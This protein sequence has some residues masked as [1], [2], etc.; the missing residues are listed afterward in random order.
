MSYLILAFAAVAGVIPIVVG[1]ILVGIAPSRTD[2]VV[3]VLRAGRP[4]AREIVSLLAA[5]ISHQDKAHDGD[6][7]V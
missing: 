2:A 6:G 1:L 7:Q 4:T 5:V 3:A